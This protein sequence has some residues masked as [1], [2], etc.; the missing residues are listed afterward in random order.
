MPKF[1][2]NIINNEIDKKNVEAILKRVENNTLLKKEFIDQNTAF[3]EESNSAVLKLISKINK[4][5]VYDSIRKNNTQNHI[6]QEIK[7]FSTKF[8]RDNNI[9]LISEFN[10]L[11]SENIADQP[12]PYIY[13]KLALDLKTILLTNFKTHQNFNGKM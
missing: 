10:S 12:A 13:E 6:I 3:L 8:Q 11:I 2:N 1:L 4:L 7:A 5:F 9:L